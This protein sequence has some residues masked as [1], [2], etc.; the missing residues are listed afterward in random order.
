MINEIVVEVE[1]TAKKIAALSEGKLSFFAVVDEAKVNEGNIYLGKI[2]KKIQTARGNLAYFVNI[3]GNEDVF[4]NAEE[5]GLEKLE[6]H[7]GQDIILQVLQEKHAEKAAK[8]SRFLT[9]AGVNLV[10]LPYGEDV[11]VS[12]KIVDEEKREALYQLLIGKACD[13]GWVIRTNAAEASFQEIL[14]EAEVLQDFFADIIA[15][16]KT[17]NSPCLLFSKDTILQEIINFA[18]EDLLRITTNSHLLEEQFREKYNVEFSAKPFAQ[19]GVDEMIQEALEKE[20][21]LPCGGRIFIEE[22][23]AFVAI[24]VDSA[25]GVSQGGLGRLNQ[26]A[27]AE[28]ARQIILRNLSGKIIIDFAGVAEYK[29]LRGV[30]E[31]LEEE[32]EKDMSKARV[33][34]LSRAGNVEII[35]QRRRP[36]L[37]DLFMEEC[38]V[39]HG[40]GRVEK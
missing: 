30:I 15:K 9:F 31:L 23:K 1:N 26:E 22:T 32:L 18:G 6:A 28:I 38:Q 2:T 40:T 14:K 25:S 12:S 21:K 10:Y 36:S 11:E 19:E 20:V 7:E 37:S 29:F 27:A 35:R 24:D 16:A 5:H 4:I 34:G 3:G 8:M 33:L 39:C 13:G 17:S